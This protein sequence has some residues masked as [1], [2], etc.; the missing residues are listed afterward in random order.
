MVKSKVSVIIPNYNYAHFIEETMQSVIN[1][2]YENWE[3]IV[4]DDNSTDNSREVIEN[5][6]NNNSEYDIRLIHNK[7]GPS[8]T[9]TPINIGIKNMS[10]EYFAW[11]SSDDVFL[12]EKLER[13]IE[14]FK[15][16][17]KIDF[18][19]TAYDVI[20]DKGF[21][22]VKNHIDYNKLTRTE[23]LIQSLNNNLI[24]GNTVLIKKEVFDKIGVFQETSEKN[25]EIWLVTEYLKWLEIILNGY[26]YY[27]DEKLHNARFHNRNSSVFKSGLPQELSGI[28]IEGFLEKN[29]FDSVYA[30]LNIV[31]ER[32]IINFETKIA[33]MLIRR[34][35]ISYLFKRME[36]IKT[37]NSLLFE[38]VQNNLVKIESLRKVSKAAALYIIKKDY[39][40]ILKQKVEYDVMN[41]LDIKYLYNIGSFLKKAG[42]IDKAIYTF[43]RLIEN[44]IYENLLLMAGSNFHLG[45]IYYEKGEYK[46]AKIYFN[47]CLKINSKHIK[48]GEYLT[49]LSNNKTERKEL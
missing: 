29:D 26:V 40:K 12:P 46:K 47:K 9:P 13:Q 4:V 19:F 34:E 8:G 16:N 49:L 18:T 14:V 31:D 11:L 17:P 22:T 6:I 38:N 24:N 43:E 45:E 32:E 30:K 3:M 20:D 23:F 42:N 7:T 28:A 15:S 48:A 5:F 33:L 27:V 44:N 41:Y 35:R 2:T 39:K 1:Q 36:K 25:P 21:I 37:Y 10:G